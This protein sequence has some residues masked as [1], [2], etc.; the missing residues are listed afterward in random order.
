MQCSR[1]ATVLFLGSGI[2]LVLADSAQATETKTYAYD[3]L[4]RLVSVISTGTLN[5]DESRTYCY[6]AAGN[7]TEVV[8]DTSGAMAACTGAPPPTSANLA[9]ADAAIIEGGVLSFAVTRSGNTSIVAS[10]NYSTSN[11]TALAPDDFSSTSGIVS[12]ASNETNKTISVST[13][14]DAVVESVENMT[15]N[16]SNPSS[17]AAITDSSG[18]GTINDNGVSSANLAI[19]DAIVT[20][21]GILSFAVTRSGNT[22]IVASVSYDTSN[23]TAI[24]PGDYTSA[25]SIVSFAVNETSKT[26][27]VATVDDSV[28]EPTESMVVILSNPSSNATITDGTGSGTI[29]DNDLSMIAITDNNLIVL[30]AHQST[31]DC[32]QGWIPT[33]FYL[34]LCSL[35]SNGIVVFQRA[36]YGGALLDPGYSI[37]NPVQLPG[38]QTL[39][40]DSANYGTGVSP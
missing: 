25:S 33:G 23:G 10:A 9:I 1:L 35:D 13:V 26:I 29:T 11:G 16:L 28:V 21:G 32:W 8:A 40:V 37:Q 15:V 24:A 12:F 27:S 30:P 7:R 5:D 38:Q 20:E 14:D 17:S 4:G 6:D 19:A 39:S 22:S 34:E 2:G 36:N 31:Y 3:A 18:I